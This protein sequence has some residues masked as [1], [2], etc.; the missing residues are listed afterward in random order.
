MRRCLSSLVFVFVFVLALLLPFAAAQTITTTDALGETIVEAI[1]TDALGEATT[2]ILQTLTP[3]ATAVTVTL[4]DAAGQ[5]VVELITGDGL[6]DSPNN[7]PGPGPSRPARHEH[8]DSGGTHTVYIHND[9]CN[10]ATT[11]VLATFTPSF[12]TTIPPSLTFKATVLDYS[13]YLTSYVTQVA[14][15]N[16]D[17]GSNGAWKQGS[18]LWG[19]C[20]ATLFTV[21]GGYLLVG[22]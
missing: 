13:A 14:T 9:R 22:A 6:G 4:Q 7:H 3:A 5:T 15:A 16:T 19:V 11:A 17:T 1:T 8:G 10:G 12:A 20:I 18:G 21:V 2:Q